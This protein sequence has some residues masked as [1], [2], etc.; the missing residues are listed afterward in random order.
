M[1]Q[2]NPEI[3]EKIGQLKDQLADLSKPDPKE[4]RLCREYLSFT[5]QSCAILA[6]VDL[7][8]WQRWESGDREMSLAH[9]ELF[10]IK[11]VFR[12]SGQSPSK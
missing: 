6:R 9:W 7:R 1:N 5:Q 11:C 8:T 12:L 4:I 2:L 3:R 10:L